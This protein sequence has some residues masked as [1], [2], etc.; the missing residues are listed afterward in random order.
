MDIVQA[1]LVAINPV[2]RPQIITLNTLRNTD[3]VLGRANF[4]DGEDTIIS[5]RHARFNV[6]PGSGSIEHLMVSNLSHVNGLLV[7]FE[8][9]PPF[10][11]TTVY[12]GDEIVPPLVL[13]FRLEFGTGLTVVFF[14]GTWLDKSDRGGGVTY[15][16][17][18]VS[19]PGNY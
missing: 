14:G 18:T 8:P 4:F 9:L 1:R 13:C 5:R 17:T 7:N 11:S 6:L 15:G 12:D 2:S 19:I 3:F 10:D 16:S